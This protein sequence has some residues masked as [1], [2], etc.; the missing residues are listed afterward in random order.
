[1]RHTPAVRESSGQASGVA[2]DPEARAQLQDEF[3]AI[4]S[5]ELRTPLTVLL[6]YLEMLQRRL[7]EEDEV[8]RR[9]TARALSQ[10]KRLADLI[11]NLLDVTRLQ[12]GKMQL[13]L[14]PVELGRVVHQTVEVARTLSEGQLIAFDPP[15]EPMVV[16]AD[17]GRLEQVVM[18]LLTNA[19][20]Y[21][22]QSERIVVRL[23]R[24]TTEAVLQVI[25]TGPGIA[26][27][28]IPNLFSRFY[29]V[30]AAQPRGSGLGLG[31]FIS[32]EIVR[33]H[34]GTIEVDS[35]EGAGSTFSVR[36][37]ITD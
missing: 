24:R 9:Y 31:L 1:M 4:A 36:L 34:G 15:V 27:A 25:D 16:P 12:H 35:T 29:Q 13:D 10:T 5:H 2:A 23:E 19:I 3:M 20:K 6:G 11:S 22:P 33:A 26:P 8:S 37:P 14:E 17:A 30:E 21:A 32:N 7:P 18:N 28:D